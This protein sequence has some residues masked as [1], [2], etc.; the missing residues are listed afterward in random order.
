[1][2]ELFGMKTYYEWVMDCDLL[3]GDFM[4][5]F[6]VTNI[7]NYRLPLSCGLLSVCSL[8]IFITMCYP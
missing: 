5:I 6:N 7:L 3:L 4:E 8:K 1:M 2:G